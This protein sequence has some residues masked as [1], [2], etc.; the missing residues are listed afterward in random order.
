[1]L[2]QCGAKMLKI[3]ACA[4]M[5]N[6]RHENIIFSYLGRRTDICSDI[7]R[8]VTEKYSAIRLSRCKC[9]LGMMNLS[10]I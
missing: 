5:V 3:S 8:D 7:M 4:S 6:G 1:M 9:Q 2:T 10:G